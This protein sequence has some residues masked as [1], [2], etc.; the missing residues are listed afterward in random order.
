MN[1][2]YSRKGGNQQTAQFRLQG[3]DSN[4]DAIGARIRVT[5]SPE[6]KPPQIFHY[7]V[8]SA[9]GFQSQNSSWQLINLM[10]MAQ[11]E[12]EVR[13]PS[14][15]ATQHAIRVGAREIFRERPPSG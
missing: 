7:S 13:W 4:R 10:G 3:V 15:R 9:E 12:V 1:T 14:G 2:L 8:R 11:A 6:G 5:V